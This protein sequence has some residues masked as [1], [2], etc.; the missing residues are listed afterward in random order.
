MMPNIQLFTYFSSPRPETIASAL[1]ESVPLGAGPEVDRGD[2]DL[3]MEHQF[4]LR[5]SDGRTGLR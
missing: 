2:Q 1:V 4:R 3:R 5:L